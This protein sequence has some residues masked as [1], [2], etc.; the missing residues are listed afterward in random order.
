MPQSWASAVLKGNELHFISFILIVLIVVAGCSNRPYQQLPSELVEDE[1]ADGM[2]V[3][4]RETL[5]SEEKWLIEYRGLETWKNEELRHYLIRRAG[6]LC[7][8]DFV[9]SEYKEFF[10]IVAH[11]K[12]TFVKYTQAMVKCN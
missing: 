9:L 10:S 3:G 7:S 12:P 6:E 5:L 4:Y 1:N 11:R 2:H 8:G